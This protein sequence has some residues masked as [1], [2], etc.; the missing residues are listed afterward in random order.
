MT[1]L[2]PV[3]MVSVN[4]ETLPSLLGE[5]EYSEADFT[6]ATPATLRKAL[7]DAGACELVS[8]NV[9][10]K[11]RQET[12]FQ[13]QNYEK[14]VTD[15]LKEIKR[16]DRNVYRVLVPEKTTP[17]FLTHAMLKYAFYCSLHAIDDSLLSFYIADKYLTLPP[18]GQTAFTAEIVI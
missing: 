15:I 17:E 4:W 11:A 10:A 12:N 5:I 6:P 7:T 14:T 2:E 9:L 13:V 1:I 18:A 16:R 3:F 8:W